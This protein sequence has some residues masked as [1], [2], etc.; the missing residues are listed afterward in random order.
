MGLLWQTKEPLR[1]ASYVYF[2][3]S[4]IVITSTG[5]A[6]V[7]L[8]DNVFWFHVLTSEPVHDK[9]NKMS[10]SPANTQVSLGIQTDQSLRYTLNG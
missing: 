1:V 10:M 6:G 3:V 8:C 5:E 9:T 7:V 4:C 2:V